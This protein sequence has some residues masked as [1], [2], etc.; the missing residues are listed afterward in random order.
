MFSYEKK[1][2]LLCGIIIIC[3]KSKDA[4]SKVINKETVFNLTL[5]FKVSLIMKNLLSQFWNNEDG[6]TA[7][8]YAMIGVGMAVIL[9][10]LF[11]SDGKFGGAINSAFDKIAGKISGAGTPK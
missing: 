7:I 4:A 9:G 3:S 8:E 6:V 11:A 10:A 2:A 1:L 5:T